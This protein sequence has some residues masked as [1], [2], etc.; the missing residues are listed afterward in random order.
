MQR[1]HQQTQLRLVLELCFVNQDFCVSFSFHA[2]VI[3]EIEEIILNI[4]GRP[5]QNGA[6]T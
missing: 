6:P 1:L 5:G 4:T 3:L 2:T